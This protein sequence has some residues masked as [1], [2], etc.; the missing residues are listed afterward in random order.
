MNYAEIF[1]LLFNIYH[2]FFYTN[3]I[4][5]LNKLLKYDII[6]LYNYAKMRTIN[7]L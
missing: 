1:I 2:Y 4:R 6:L 5:V 7:T 3:L